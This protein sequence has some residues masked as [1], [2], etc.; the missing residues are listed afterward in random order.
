MNMKNNKNNK[1][2]KG[3]RG[4]KY[5]DSDNRLWPPWECWYP[6]SSGISPVRVDLERFR[7]GCK[8]RTE[9]EEKNNS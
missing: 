6:R 3:C 1:N 2:N 8:G 9:D 5:L 7:K 4:C